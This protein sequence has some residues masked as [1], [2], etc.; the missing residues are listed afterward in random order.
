MSEIRNLVGDLLKKG[1]DYKYIL[2]EVVSCVYDTVCCPDCLSEVRI[3]RIVT[4]EDV[5]NYVVSVMHDETCP[6]ADQDHPCT[7]GECPD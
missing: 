1:T 7:C 5:A 6:N 4:N 3:C 2:K